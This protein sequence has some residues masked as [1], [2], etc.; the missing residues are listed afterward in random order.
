MK[1]IGGLL[2]LPYAENVPLCSTLK[3]NQRLALPLV[4]PSGKQALFSLPNRAVLNWNAY[5]QE[6]IFRK[7]S[8]RCGEKS[9]QFYHLF[10]RRSGGF[11]IWQRLRPAERMRVSFR[12]DKQP[13]VPRRGAR[14]NRRSRPNAIP[15]QTPTSQRGIATGPSQLRACGYATNFCRPIGRAKA[16]QAFSTPISRFLPSASNFGGEPLLSWGTSRLDSS[17]DNRD[18]AFRGSVASDGRESPAPTGLDAKT[19]ITNNAEQTLF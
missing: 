10:P 13:K 9:T 11:A 4:Y 6:T 2:D 1:S 14:Q 8:L 17:I 19:A 15:P 16:E 18:R 3:S 7:N 12:H 5:Y